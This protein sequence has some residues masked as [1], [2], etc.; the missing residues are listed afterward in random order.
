[1][2]QVDRAERE[3]MHRA[4]EK[5]ETERREIREK[6]AAERKPLEAQR[7]VLH[8]EYMAQKGAQ[9]PTSP[10][11]QPAKTTTTGT[12]TQVSGTANDHHDDEWRRHERE[13]LERERQERERRE[14]ERR[15]WRK[16]HP[17][18][19][20]TAPQKTTTPTGT[21]ASPAAGGTTNAATTH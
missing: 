16:T 12:K 14:R 20:G 1:M 21:G 2:E 7:A 15:E 9:G 6:Y 10:V 3:E 11:T 8:Q 5:Y 18:N 17:T 13:R 19:G 4:V